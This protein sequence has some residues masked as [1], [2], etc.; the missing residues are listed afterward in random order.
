[1]FG[2]AQSELQK[3]SD[4]KAFRNKRRT[5][6]SQI[7]RI[8]EL[9]ALGDGEQQGEDSMAAAAAGPA[10]RSCGSPTCSGACWGFHGR[11][12]L[13]SC[14]QAGEA[15]QRREAEAEQISGVADAAE[16]DRC[17]C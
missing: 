1:M 5:L 8:T 11:G 4:G 10:C 9:L 16:A 15:D 2:T 14:K 7:Q 12:R 6:R 13:K 17:G 3:I